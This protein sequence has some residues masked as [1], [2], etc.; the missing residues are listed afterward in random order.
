MPPRLL[1]LQ[2]HAGSPLGL[3][4]ERFAARGAEM[5]VID[6]A[7]GC[8]LPED[9]GGADGLVILGG[10]V[11]AYDD[12]ACP[13]FPALMTLIQAMGAQGRPV[14][15]ICLGAQLI[16]RALG[17]A[18]RLNSTPEFGFVDLEALPAATDDPVVRGA[19]AGLPV[20]QWHDDSFDLPE[21]A[22][23]LLAGARCR[24]QAFRWG[25]VV[26]GF[27]CHLEATESMA[28]SWGAER[29]RMTNNPAV[30]VRLGAE[31]RRH[32]ERAARFGRSVADGWLDLVEAA[33]RDR[34][35][36]G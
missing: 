5:S 9:A 2:H 31:I 34:Q 6:A 21:G 29:G 10:V 7:Q 14:L 13:H 35:P 33:V 1:V 19:G 20:M 23:L 8:E 36:K 18:V 30:G 22:E 4:G 25:E 26:Y 28:R 15:G 27:Q 17:A 24:N 3:L 11:N 32:H 12:S 16:A